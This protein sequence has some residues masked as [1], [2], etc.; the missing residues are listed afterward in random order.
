MKNW[1]GR[2]TC[3]AVRGSSRH[4]YS[5]FTDSTLARLELPFSTFS[6]CRCSAEWDLDKLHDTS[7]KVVVWQG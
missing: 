4:V 5:C 2:L 3:K 1:M 7:R 6:C